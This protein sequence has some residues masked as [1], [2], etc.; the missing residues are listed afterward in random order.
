MM[1]AIL[2]FLNFNQGVTQSILALVL[3]VIT[4]YYAFQSKKLVTLTHKQRVDNV[5]PIVVAQDFVVHSDIDKGASIC[6]DCHFKNIGAGPAFILNADFYTD[7]GK[8]LVFGSSHYIDFLEKGK[9]HKKHI[10]VLKK[11]WG[12][13]KYRNHSDMGVIAPFVVKLTFYDIFKNKHITTQEFVL[14]KEGGRIDAVIGTLKL[15]E[16]I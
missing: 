7:G 12:K 13:I 5:L 15:E 6:V 1:Q 14:E 8:N 3:A 9:L 2:D 16:T 11:N 4:A 10:H